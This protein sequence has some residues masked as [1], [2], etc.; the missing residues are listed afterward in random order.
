MVLEEPQVVQTP[1]ATEPTE[2]EPT[3]EETAAPLAT[4]TLPPDSPT[5]PA[6]PGPNVTVVIPTEETATDEEAGPGSETPD[7]DD[8]SGIP[9]WLIVIGVIVVVGLIVLV[10][11]GRTG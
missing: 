9:F 3:I 5:E 1:P 7:S 8:G 11:R 10:A 6:E 2:P 4:E